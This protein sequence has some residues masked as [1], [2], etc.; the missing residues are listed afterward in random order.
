MRHYRNY[1]RHLSYRPLSCPAFLSDNINPC[2]QCLRRLF[3]GYAD[4]RHNKKKQLWHKKI[5]M[6][7]T[8]S[9]GSYL[10]SLYCT[11]LKIIFKYHH[12]KGRHFLHI[13]HLQNHPPR[14][15]PALLFP[16]V[17]SFFVVLPLGLPGLPV[18]PCCFFTESA[19][20]H[21]LPFP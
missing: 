4:G 1:K 19:T 6:R 9:Y 12:L 17:V 18:L 13:P 21:S 16:A 11:A 15:Q 2:S 3:H 14:L 5:H 10:S 8:A 20:N 7:Q